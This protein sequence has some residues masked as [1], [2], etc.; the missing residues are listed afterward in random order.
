MVFAPQSTGDT[1]P[2]SFYELSGSGDGYLAIDGK[3]IPIKWHHDG[4]DGPFRFT[5]ADGTT[6]ITLGIGTTYCAIADTSGRFE[7]E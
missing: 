2:N 5:L 1:C 3:Y 6:P 7:A 4:I